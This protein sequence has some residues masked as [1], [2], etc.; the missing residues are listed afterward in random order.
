MYI[1]AFFGTSLDQHKKCKIF[2]HIRIETQLSQSIVMHLSN[3]FL[4]AFIRLFSFSPLF[5]SSAQPI[6]GADDRSIKLRRRR[7]AEFSGQMICPCRWKCASQFDIYRQKEIFDEYY[8][9][10]SWRRKTLFLRKIVVRY[11][12][13]AENI[14][15]PSL[16][17]DQ[18]NTNYYIIWRIVRD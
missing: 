2:V 12:I 3:I 10:R 1:S 17:R 5:L 16:L 7:Q 13:D 8:S 9:L 11:K 18:R 14:R 4:F 15:I 6:Q